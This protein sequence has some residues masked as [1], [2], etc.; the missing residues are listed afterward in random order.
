VPFTICGTGVSPDAAA[1]YDEAAASKSSL[2]FEEG[3]KLMGHF[4]R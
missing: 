2:A 3:W 4:L 1:T